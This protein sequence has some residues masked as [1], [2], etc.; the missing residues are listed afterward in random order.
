VRAVRNP[1]QY[2]GWLLLFAVII[3]GMVA[4]GIAINK[5]LETSPT[6]E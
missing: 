2:W 3:G 6:A 4:S 1:G 5:K